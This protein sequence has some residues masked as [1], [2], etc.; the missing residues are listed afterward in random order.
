MRGRVGPAPPGHDSTCN[1]QT[2][3]WHGEGVPVRGTESPLPIEATS[4]ICSMVGAT[5]HLE[6]AGDFIPG[7]CGLDLPD[8][9]RPLQSTDPALGSVR[10]VRGSRAERVAGGS[11]QDRTQQAIAITATDPA[12]SYQLHPRGGCEVLARGRGAPGGGDSCRARPG[13]AGPAPGC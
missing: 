12:L 2:K 9:Y 6:A 8:Q 11:D 1:S 13:L 7:V 10:A 5:R 3:T 4:A